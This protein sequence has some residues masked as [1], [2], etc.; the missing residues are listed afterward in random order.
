[1]RAPVRGRCDEGTARPQT[2]SDAGQFRIATSTQPCLHPP[3]PLRP[4]FSTLFL[5]LTL[6]ASAGP[7]TA[8]SALQ[9][10]SAERAPRRER[11]ALCSWDRPGHNP[12]M[13][14]V[15]AAIDRNSDIPTP[16]RVRLKQRM[17]ARQYDEMVDIRRDSIR[18]RADYQPTIRD[19]HFGLDRVCA[20]VSRSGWTPAMHERGLVYCESGHCILVPTVCRNVSRIERT[21]AAIAGTSASDGPGDAGA[22]KP[23]P[24]PTAAS[25]ER[26]AGDP[27]T[28]AS[29]A[30]LQATSSFAEAVAGVAVALFPLGDALG[31][32]LDEGLGPLGPGSGLGGVGSPSGLPGAGA[33]SGGPG[34]GDGNGNGTSAGGPV[35][36][37]R[38]IGFLSIPPLGTAPGSFEGGVP[39]VADLVA[40]ITA[41]P[42]PATWA[43]LLLG[44]GLLALVSARRAARRSPTRAR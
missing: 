1:M 3:V 42:E 19:M 30:Q 21:P 34:A 14:D 44:L 4:I 13:G 28:P 36:D 20:Q 22:P 25:S 33:S 8:S 9:D 16:V 35:D 17:Q 37:G 18:G 26:F 6:L 43:S 11:V 41:V 15:V 10:A 40:P 27:E 31:N 29:V 39:P 23:A 12:F 2:R 7:A 5:L 24:G 38:R 32:A